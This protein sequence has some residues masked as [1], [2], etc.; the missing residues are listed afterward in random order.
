MKDGALGG[1]RSRFRRGSHT[2]TPRPQGTAG[3]PG[4]M[5]RM[6]NEAQHLGAGGEY[7]G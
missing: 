7:S 1:G 6:G 4:K 2:E 5:E 3:I